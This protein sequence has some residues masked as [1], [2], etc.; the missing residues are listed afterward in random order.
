MVVCS[1][2]E[3][4]VE[5]THRRLRSA[6]SG[7]GL[8]EIRGDHLGEADLAGLVGGAGRPVVV[9]VRRTADG[10]FFDGSEEQ[11]RGMLRAALA[12]GAR[13]IDVEHGSA[14]RDLAEGD[15]AERVI[16]SHHGAECGSSEL[17]AT[18]RAMA[19]SAAARLKI[20]PAARSIGQAEAVR[21]L[22]AL[23]AREGRML[24]C[25]ATGRAG[26]ITRLL[27][28]VW[29]SWASYGSH[30]A[31]ASTADGQ[32]S[33]DEMLETHGVLGLGRSTRR[34]ALLGRSVFGS[35]SPAMHRAGYRHTGL[36]ARYF[37]IEVDDFEE[38]LPLLEPR[39]VLGVEA[40]ALTIPFKQAAFRQ[41]RTCDDVARESGSVNTVRLESQGWAGYN[42][43]GPAMLQLVR[44][45]MDPAGARAAIVGAGGTARTA[46]VVLRNAGASVR[47]FNRT[48]SRAR[49]AADELGVQA[50]SL[51][52]LE[53]YRWDVLIQATPLGGRGE[54]VLPAERLNGVL[55]L[56]AVYGVRTPLA[57][58]AA[59]RGLRVIDGFEL[60]VAQAA[61]QFERMTGAKVP[62]GV[63]SAAGRG[64]LDAR[65][66]AAY[67]RS[68]GGLQEK[69]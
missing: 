40:L 54:V 20:V 11:R 8:V 45:Q 22:L 61:L 62:A 51:N 55:V 18:Y 43:D 13:F 64:W 7:C 48:E 33:V 6:P 47:L 31:G 1:I 32:F 67:P 15:D 24:A 57:T 66:G 58:D 60:L 17:L 28:P 30:A 10:G 9:T 26:A 49:Q 68:S 50:G 29:G 42:T 69:P 23:A 46:A 52:E 56:D 35:P 19:T 59:R 39:G 4:T 41:C 25:F 44:G 16:L 34:F 36:D 3:R 38:C 63:L 2:L 53:S 5:A 21:D 27:A 14:L 37:P 12:S 65:S